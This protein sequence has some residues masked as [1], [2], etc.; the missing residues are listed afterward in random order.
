VSKRRISVVFGV[1]AWL[2]LLATTSTALNP[3][4]LATSL[5]GVAVLVS[6]ASIHASQR[7]ARLRP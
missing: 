7:D 3:H 6:L 4:P 2:A 1:L 5:F